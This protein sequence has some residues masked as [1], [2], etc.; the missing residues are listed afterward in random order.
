MVADGMGAHA[1]GELASKL[2]VD[3]VPLAYQKLADRAPP[4]AL[5]AAV[6]DANAQIHGRGRADPDF[7]GMGTTSTT[8]VL[9][10][11]GAV[12]AQVGDS[13]AYRLRGDQFAQLT[14]DHSL[15][16]EMRAAGQL[17][18]DQVPEYIPR[19]V[20]T[21]SLGPSPTVKVDIEGPFPLMVGDTFLLCSDGLS[22]QVKDAEMGTILQCLP[23]AEAARTLIDLANLRGGPDNITL[24][25][26][27]LTA[28]LPLNKTA[29]QPKPPIHRRPVPPAVWIVLTAL[30]LLGL[31][32]L[33]MGHPWLGLI[34]LA[35]AGGVG[36]GAAVWHCGGG[37]D[38]SWARS[39]HGCGPYV[40][41]QCSPNAEF[42][43]QLASIA[44]EV[45]DAATNGRWAVD[46][47]QFNGKMDC[48]TSACQAS[49]Y[50]QAVSCF[51]QAISFI[52]GE[53]RQQRRA[54]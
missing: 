11:Q 29:D 50:V 16:W 4:D 25:L 27:R 19:N 45:R 22:G 1:A 39:H 18:G 20:I 51:C 36:A 47:V 8:L 13:R 31:G 34:G 17:P 43:K 2:A 35:A 30:V 54:R 21:R 28:P 26:I 14:F 23:L 9:L 12:A 38:L 37:P 49:D 10:P 48:G 15:V 40:V 6:E 53:L 44:R 46:W 24:V 3:I 33:V 52:M 5:R 7:R 32:L 41:S 42:A